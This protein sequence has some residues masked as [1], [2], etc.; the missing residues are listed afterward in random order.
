MFWDPSSGEY[1]GSQ[2]VAK[3]DYSSVVLN[4][5]PDKPPASSALLD[6]DHGYVGLLGDRNEVDFETFFPDVNV[7]VA[8]DNLYTPLFFF[9]RVAASISSER[10]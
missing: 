9:R 1:L 8:R 3:V 10:V 2:N 5:A 6:K 7:A 4:C